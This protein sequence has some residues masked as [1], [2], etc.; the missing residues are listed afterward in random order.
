MVIYPLYPHLSFNDPTNPIQMMIREKFGRNLSST[1]IAHR[2]DIM[3]LNHNTSWA[4]G[5]QVRQRE[6]KCIDINTPN[7]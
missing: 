3:N 7:H 6:I 2:Q 1:I 5:Y 4:V